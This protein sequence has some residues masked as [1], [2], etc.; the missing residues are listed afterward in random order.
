[1]KKFKI[2]M[3]AVMAIVLGIA[4]SAFTAKSTVKHNHTMRFIEFT[5]SDNSKGQ[6]EASGNW[7]DLGTSE[8]ILTCD[9]GSGIV[10]YVQYNGTL[11]QFQSYVANKTF[12]DL[13]NAG[14]IQEYRAS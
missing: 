7:L 1:M 9:E 4:A 11:T 3:I 13:Q 12:T 14:I 2:S 5:C 8:P 10:C 6:I